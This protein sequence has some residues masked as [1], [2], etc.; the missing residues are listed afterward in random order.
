[1]SDTRLPLRRTFRCP[2]CGYDQAKMGTPKVSGGIDVN[3]QMGCPEC[4]T[5]RGL[6]VWLEETSD[7][8]DVG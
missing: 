4:A 3:F 5:V 7:P 1:M 2:Q 6:V 8:R